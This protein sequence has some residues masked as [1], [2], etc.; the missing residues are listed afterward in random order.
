[1][2][3]KV[4]I[5]MSG[6]VDSSVA[7]FLMLQKGYE[8]SGVTMKLHHFSEEDGSEPGSCL[9]STAAED[10]RIVAEALGI[11]FSVCHMEDLFQKSVIDQFVHSYL[12]GTT[13]NPCICCNRHLKFNALLNEATAQGMD[14][15]A[16]GH[17]AQTF[18]DSSSN[19]WML[20]KGID[21]SKDQSYVLYSLTQDQLSHTIFPLGGYKK[22][23]IREIAEE[24][25]FVNAHK[26][27]SQDICFIPDGDYA[28][29][30]ERYTGKKSPEGNFVLKDGT[31][32]G[33]HKGMIRYTLGQRRGLGVSYKES[34]Y[35]CEKLMDTNTVVLG[36]NSDLF[37]KEFDVGDLN[38]IAFDHLEA[39]VACK[40]KTRYRHKEQPA[41]ITQTGP[42]RI[43]VIFDEPQRAITPG[44]AAVFYDGDLVL[45]GGTIL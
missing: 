24:Q 11:P 1:M 23:E 9:S 43:H 10:A 37:Q 18:F 25:G 44:Q 21:S 42:D 33:T 7:A 45:G 35:V 26:S 6:G 29:F 39:P 22:T 32:V 8:C 40:V 17:Y 5:A 3:K 36:K 41:Y 38:L 2:G 15:I 16:S 20:K 31:I 28:S 30:I 34:L 4:M 12:R 27:E 13:P 19:R 14:M